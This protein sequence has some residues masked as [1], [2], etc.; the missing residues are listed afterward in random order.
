MKFLERQGFYQPTNAN[1]KDFFLMKVTLI[2]GISRRCRRDEL[3]R[4]DVEDVSGKSEMYLINIPHTKTKHFE[5]L[6]RD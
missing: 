1:N 5:N 3:Y 6:S 2:I 4:M